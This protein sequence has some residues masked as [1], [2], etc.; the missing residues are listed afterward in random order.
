MARKTP[1]EVNITPASTARGRKPLAPA[2]QVGPDFVGKTPIAMAEPEALRNQVQTAY[3]DERDLLNQLLG[4]SQMAA[5][6]SKLLTVISLT[7]LAHI[8]ETK[9]YRAFAGKS[10]LSPSGVE[11]ADVGTWDGFCELIGTSQKKV[12]EDLLNLRIF[13]EDAMNQLSSIGA[14]YRDLRKLRALPNDARTGL[15]E[16][17]EAKQALASGDKD[18]LRELIEDM[19]VENVKLRTEKEEL[20]ANAEAHEKIMAGKDAKVN[21]LDKRLKK[22]ER[23][24][25]TL[26]PDDKLAEI[27][28]EL[29]G[30]AVEAEGAIVN[31]LRPAFQM[32]TEHIAE[33]GGACD[34]YLSGCLGQ[35]EQRLREL[36]EEYGLNQADVAAWA[37]G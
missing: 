6:T 11:I 8:K 12:D 31:K 17:P 21:E 25:A 26:D 36:R 37:N 2:E 29:L 19:A 3:A 30:F 34:E 33:H 1:T 14:G 16:S 7:K 24:V 9:L 27:R 10:A 22:A 5:A 32:L 28:A 4:Q 13:G 23:R 15:L 35:I 20:E 18:A